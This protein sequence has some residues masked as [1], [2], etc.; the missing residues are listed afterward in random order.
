MNK[1]NGWKIPLIAVIPGY[2]LSEIA[3]AMVFMKL[4]SRHPFA[5]K[6]IFLVLKKVASMLSAT[7][8]LAASEREAS[9]HMEWIWTMLSMAVEAIA[10]AASSPAC[11]W[12]ETS[13]KTSLA[14]VSSFLD[15]SKKIFPKLN[16]FLIPFSKVSRTW[17]D[18]SFISNW[19]IH[20]FALLNH[21]ARPDNTIAHN[22]Y[23]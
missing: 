2:S 5:S 4:A 12:S 14:V 17:K 15:L 10:L 18:E 7:Q 22:A 8:A 16:N 6:L 11:T 13:F 9:K 3:W 23:L 19:G 1:R 20:L 21:W